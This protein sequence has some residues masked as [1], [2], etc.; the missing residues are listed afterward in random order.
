M[1]RWVIGFLGVVVLATT[2]CSI[3]ISKRSP[4]DVQRL[5]ELSDQLNQ[6]K[7]FSGLNSEE[8]DQ[9]RHAKALLEQRFGK[10]ELT[11]GYDERGLVARVVDRVLF[12]SGKAALRPNAAEILTRLV[13]VLSEIP[14][15]PIGVEGHTDNVPIKHSGWEDNQS[16]SMARAMAVV[17]YFVKNNKISES[18]ITPIGYGEAKPIASNET[19]QGRAQNRRVEIVLLPKSSNSSYKTEAQRVLQGSSGYKK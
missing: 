16:L 13:G 9:F 18:R 1:K 5:A 15:L 17:E 11:I 2:G 4:W 6:F 19:S 7:T 8:V 14:S 10:D 12:D 3:N